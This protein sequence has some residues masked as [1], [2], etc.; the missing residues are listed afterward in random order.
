LTRRPV[1]FALALLLGAAP[2]ALAQSPDGYLFR[3]PAGMLTLRGGY[4]VANAGSDIYSF[5]RQNLTLDRSD[6]NAGTAAFDLS[7]MATS[8]MDVS[9]GLG[10]ARS[11]AGSEFRDYIDNNNLPIEQK[12][13]LQTVP[14][15]TTLRYYLAPRGRSL[16]RYA[17]VP[18][19]IAPYV[20]L[21]GGMVWYTFRQ[22]G[23]FVDFQTLNVFNDNLSSSGRSLMGLAL[24]GANVA[25]GTR[26]ALTGEA[27]YTFA[28]APLRQDFV[29]FHSID[30]SGLS[31]T[32]GISMRLSSRGVR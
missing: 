4:S 24:A 27:R 31:F 15:S 1:S 21:G 3:P 13:S 8:R 11:S 10:I 5:A 25:M 22:T 28:T 32:G 29:G 30:L 12:T 18:A 20:G 2:A 14:L 23:D 16:G 7:F 19:R 26:W 9:F 17:W 6:F